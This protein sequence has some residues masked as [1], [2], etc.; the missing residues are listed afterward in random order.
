MTN[1]VNI[2]SKLQTLKWPNPSVVAN[3]IKD[4]LI[5]VNI[6]VYLEINDDE[7]EELD[8]DIKKSI[9][10][11]LISANNGN[12]NKLAITTFDTMK[13][14]MNKFFPEDEVF[15]PTSTYSKKKRI[16]SSVVEQKVKSNYLD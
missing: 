10:L 3:N 7:I 1:F 14:D 4:F 12:N 8:D 9:T 16:F 13:V 5:P 11:E 15:K 6:K 2:S